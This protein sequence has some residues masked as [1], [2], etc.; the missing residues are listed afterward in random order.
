[1]INQDIQIILD[2]IRSHI[3]DRL[4]LDVIS[5]QHFVSKFHF[6]RLFTGMVG[7]PP[8]RYIRL[9]KLRHSL[10]LLLTT[11][12]SVTEIAFKLGFGSHDVFTRAFKQ[13]FRGTP[14]NL[15]RTYKS[16]LWVQL[17]FSQGKD[18]F[19]M[20]DFLSAPFTVGDKREA[21]DTIE[22]LLKLSELTK[23]EGSL[24]LQQ[25]GKDEELPL[26]LRKAIYM[27]CDGWSP[28]M[29]KG[30]LENYMKF[31]SYQGAELLKRLLIAE[32]ILSI[33]AGEISEILLEK[34]LS[35]LG[36]EFFEEARKRIGETHVQDAENTDYIE[37]YFANTE[38]NPNATNLA[39]DALLNASD[40]AI[41]QVMCEVDINIFEPA[42][43]GSSKQLQRKF[44][45]NISD[46]LAMRFVRY[47]RTAT[48]SQDTIVKSQHSLLGVFYKLKA[49]GII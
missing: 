6:H 27:I 34:L 30:I 4:A 42:F 36:E 8:A 1:M 20:Y 28:E 37:E 15:R 17:H 47:V 7:M 9:Q 16:R 23:N 32:G 49:D 44:C 39:E 40:C 46:R 22:L 2:Y 24:A 31:S 41:R 45:N 21:M 26:F 48:P 3:Y 19:L 29:V 13:K 12:N 5:E 14:A 33:Q 11:D 43:Y 25:F 18:D 10:W 35:Y 38:E